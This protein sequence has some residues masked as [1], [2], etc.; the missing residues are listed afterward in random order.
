MYAL[1]GP[2]APSALILWHCITPRIA[3][4]SIAQIMAPAAPLAPPADPAGETLKPAEHKIS[5]RLSVTLCA[6][7]SPSLEVAFLIML[8]LVLIKRTS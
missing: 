5:S 2:P 6:R 7:K 4:H 3:A 8:S 1:A